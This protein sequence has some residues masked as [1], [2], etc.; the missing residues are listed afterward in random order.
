[1]SFTF[2]ITR[3]APIGTVVVVVRNP[4]FGDS[5]SSGQRQ[6]TGETEGGEFYIQPLG[7]ETKFYEGT[8]TNL[9]RCELRDLEFFFGADG[10]NRRQRKF[11]MGVVDNENLAFP[12]GTGQGWNTAADLNT[13]LLVVPSSASF[14]E[15]RLEQSQVQFSSIPRDRFTTSLR[16]RILQ[17]AACS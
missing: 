6:A 5:H 16:F 10:S 9:N 14:G 12:I 2:E 8:W 4:E 15:V 17:P 13:G 3:P 7:V 1:M 11:L